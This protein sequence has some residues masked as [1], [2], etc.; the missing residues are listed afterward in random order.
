MAL[1][2]YKLKLQ[3]IKT[4]VVMKLQT[5]S[6][7]MFAEIKLSNVLI[8]V[9]AILGFTVAQNIEIRPDVNDSLL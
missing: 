4:L 6:M 2:F 9:L 8:L 3:G 5:R 7:K 1:F